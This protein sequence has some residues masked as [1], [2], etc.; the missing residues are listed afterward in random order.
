MVGFSAA[1][2][3]PPGVRF[4]A[5]AE[6]SIEIVIAAQRDAGEAAERRGTE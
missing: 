2:R 5:R 4:P 1:S 6:G 3:P